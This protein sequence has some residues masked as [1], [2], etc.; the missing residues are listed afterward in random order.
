MRRDIVVGVVAGLTV[1]AVTV[2]VGALTGWL[3]GLRHDHAL[4]C[5]TTDRVRG[6]V[7]DCRDGYVVTGCSAGDNR[8]S[9]R[10]DGAGNRC[11]TDDADTDWT[12][13]RC[14]RLEAAD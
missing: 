3:E 13:A 5:Y 6:R 12:E 11:V 10:H 1:A 4:V 14:C 2:G 7:A 9:I 8:G